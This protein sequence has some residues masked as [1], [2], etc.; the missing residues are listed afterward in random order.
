MSCVFLGQVV[1]WHL[2]L[3]SGGPVVP[4]IWRLRL[5]TV[6]CPL[7]AEAQLVWCAL[8][9][10]SAVFRCSTA[11]GEPQ[12]AV[13][14]AQRLVNLKVLFAN[15]VARILWQAEHLANLELQISWQA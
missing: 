4:A 11:L 13:F 9:A 12:S 6:S 7:P 2:R 5:G 8:W 10:P 1:I 14:V 3:R 15:L